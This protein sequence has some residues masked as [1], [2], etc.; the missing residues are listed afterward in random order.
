[1]N[2]SIN[3]KVILILT[4]LI[5]LQ[6]GNGLIAFL[7]TNQLRNDAF[8]V[9]HTHEVMNTMSRVLSKLVDAESGQRG[10]IITGSPSFLEPYLNAKSQVDLALRQLKT[11]TRD[12][13]TQQAHISAVHSLAMEK[14]A[15]MDLNI[16][17]RRD[18]G[19]DRARERVSGGEGKN[20]MDTIR[21]RFSKMYVEEETLLTARAFKAERSYQIALLSS[22]LAALAGMALA[23]TA[24]YF[25]RRDIQTRER[26]RVD[27]HNQKE[28]FST[29]LSSI[30]DAVIVT[31][32]NGKVSFIN[33]VAQTLTGW[34][35]GDAAGQPLVKIF[36]IVNEETRRRVADP[37]AKVIESGAITGLAN[38][39]L[40]IARDGKEHPIDDSAAPIRGVDGKILGVVLVFRDITERKGAEAALLASERELRLITDIAPV[41]LARIDTQ[42]RY[43]FVNKGYADRFGLDRDQVI[44]K[45][46]PEVVGEEAFSTFKSYV[47]RALAGELVE[48]EVEIPYQD[49]GVHYMHVTYVPEHDAKERVQGFVAVILDISARKRIEDQL[50]RAD[51]SKD[52]FLAMLGHELR[53]PLA[54]I[55]TAAEILRRLGPAEPTVEKALLIIERQIIHLTRLVDDLLDV[56]RITQGKIV[57]QKE[58]IELAP[59]LQHA[60]DT[61][62][63]LIESRHQIVN[64]QL[65]P[66]PIFVAGDTV[67]LTQIFSNLLNNAA[68]YT[69]DNGLIEIRAELELEVVKI[70]VRDNGTGISPELLP[71]VFELFTQAQRD[72]DR[73]QGGLG[74]GLTLVRRLVESH[75]GIVSA[76][77]AGLGKGSEFVVTLPVVLAPTAV[78][79]SVS[80]PAVPPVSVKRKILVVDDNVDSAE[81]MAMVLEL[82]GHTIHIAH[83][84]ETALAAAT[85]FLPEVVL[86]DIGLPG[87]DG[88]EVAAR[89][90]RLPAT[91]RAVL[92]AFTGYSQ[93]EDRRRA[94][95]AGFDHYVVK[96]VDLDALAK[97]IGSFV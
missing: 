4:F 69:H 75:G 13:L 25:Y 58:T 60:L 85:S 34:L 28:W 9:N 43:L 23:L 46:I 10:Y 5:A 89:L 88:Y 30:G 42:H 1:M 52:E 14:F 53:N 59:I 33:N 20:M 76:S 97:L 24:V 62:H 26:A 55:R 8:R 71:R 49:I 57:L 50:R 38:H 73:S 15:T 96:P 54:P 35:P 7:T 51:Q 47:D 44:G 19:F 81:T 94:T 72:A 40:L 16:Q 36:N 32:A 77:S 56:S 17:T 61:T 67:R 11:L 18:E 41:Y 29:T 90:R 3:T 78:A 74:V 68:K 48:F 2:G 87:L 70:H 66:T 63:P 6:I 93:P 31:D 80:A 91:Q 45:R 95:E 39:T 22:V 21:D 37:V 79:L 83:D 64:I 12:N 82:D 65:P 86:L 84:G 92:V 27:L